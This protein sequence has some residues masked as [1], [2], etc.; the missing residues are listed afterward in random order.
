MYENYPEAEKYQLF[1]MYGPKFVAAPHSGFLPGV[2]PTNA[3]YTFLAGSVE[4]KFEPCVKK[5]S[6]DWLR[7]KRA[8]GK[9][10]RDRESTKR[11]RKCL[12]W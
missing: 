10:D 11:I 9:N 4:V 12:K 5:K 7:L 6:L 3:T 1:R 8:F 2:R